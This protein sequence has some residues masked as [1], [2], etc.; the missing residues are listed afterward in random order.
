VA[1]VRFVYVVGDK[2]MCYCG[3]SLV[4]RAEV[5]RYM[6]CISHHAGLR[7]AKGSARK[8]TI[9]GHDPPMDPPPSG[10]VDEGGRSWDSIY[11]VLILVSLVPSTKFEHASRAPKVRHD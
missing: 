7:K 10:N 5:A 4:S 11:L 8:A 3:G 6:V 9:T 2:C 1:L